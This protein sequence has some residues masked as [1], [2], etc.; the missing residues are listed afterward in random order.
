MSSQHVNELQKK[1][2]DYLRRA[3]DAVDPQ[4]QRLWLDLARECLKLV[5]DAR[6]RSPVAPWGRGE[7]RGP[8]L[9]TTARPS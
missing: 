5:A 3:S 7:V 4:D 2:E 8:R 1:A 9:A 6:D